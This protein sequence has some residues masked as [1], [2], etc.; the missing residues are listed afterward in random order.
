MNDTADWAAERM[1]A[2]WMD[3]SAEERVLAAARMFQT[4]RAV[5]EAGIRREHPGIGGAE[6]RLRVF[7]RMYRSDFSAEAWPGWLA[8]VRA[9]LQSE[10][11]SS[12]K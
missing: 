6:L 4:A 9:R 10:V 5:V 7:E 1:Q 12:P 3:R 11:S 8:R 2:L